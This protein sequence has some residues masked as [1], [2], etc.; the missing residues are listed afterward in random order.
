VVV[1]EDRLLGSVGGIHHV[2]ENKFVISNDF[3]GTS[4]D[5]TLSLM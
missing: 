3:I 1:S 2:V 4:Q 5:L